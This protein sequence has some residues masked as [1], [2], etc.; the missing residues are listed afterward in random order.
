MKGG[1][2]NGALFRSAVG[3][4]R[5]FELQFNPLHT[6]HFKAIHPPSGEILL[7]E[8]FCT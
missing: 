7:R 8:E 4:F 3:I 5:L 1:G 6:I 2:M